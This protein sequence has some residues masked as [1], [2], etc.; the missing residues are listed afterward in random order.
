[1]FLEQ[2]SLACGY[3]CDDKIKGIEDL[4][5]VKAIISQYPTLLNEKL[6][7]NKFYTPLMIASFCNFTTV[8]AFLILHEK[9]E[10]NKQAAVSHIVD[11][12]LVLMCFFMFV[13]W[14]H[15]ITLCLFLRN[16]RNCSITFISSSY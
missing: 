9:I 11:V 4:D 13:V 10:I 16:C 1:M 12:I 6:D 8:G 5:T 15:G 7:K 14:I 3:D 2:L